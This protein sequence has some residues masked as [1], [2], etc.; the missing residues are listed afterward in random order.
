MITVTTMAKCIQCAGER[1]PLLSSPHLV[2]YI[3]QLWAHFAKQLSNDGNSLAK[4]QIEP[5]KYNK[6][7]IQFVEQRIIT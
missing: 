6:H 2:H 1:L 3:N 5:N 7:D 4:R